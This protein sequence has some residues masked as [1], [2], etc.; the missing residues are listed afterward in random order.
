MRRLRDVR[1]SIGKDR[2]LEAKGD[3]DVQPQ[4]LANAA[5]AEEG[6]QAQGVGD[7]AAHVELLAVRLC[8]GHG[9]TPATGRHIGEFREV[10]GGIGRTT[11]RSVAPTRCRFIY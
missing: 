5:D 6:Q 10:W 1:V 8:S 2:V 4:A 11:F 9:P 7:G 3:R